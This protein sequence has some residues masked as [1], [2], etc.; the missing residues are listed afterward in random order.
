MAQKTQKTG[1]LHDAARMLRLAAARLDAY[2]VAD[3]QVSYD[4]AG[5]P[6]YNRAQ[7][8]RLREAQTNIDAAQA[9]LAAYLDAPAVDR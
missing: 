8:K 5:I 9:R 1:P 4:E 7:A 2:G 6:E 3:A